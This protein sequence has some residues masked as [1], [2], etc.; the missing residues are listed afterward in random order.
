MRN[1]SP[2]LGDMSQK[3][4]P[5]PTLAVDSEEALNETTPQERDMTIKESIEEDI[6]KGSCVVEVK[7][8]D[9]SKP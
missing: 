6:A 1:V 5:S 8:E 7:K 4:F 9:A 2:Y 3:G